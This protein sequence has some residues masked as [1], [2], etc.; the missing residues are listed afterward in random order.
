M[1][2]CCV[3]EETVDKLEAFMSSIIFLLRYRM[4]LS[5]IQELSA[6]PVAAATTAPTQLA[7][8]QEVHT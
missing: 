4:M 2:E 8:K 7:T 5:T 3:R 6:P 1:A